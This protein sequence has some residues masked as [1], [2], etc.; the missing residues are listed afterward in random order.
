MNKGVAGFGIFLLLVAFAMLIKA[1]MVEDSEDLV[2][3]NGTLMSSSMMFQ[4]ILGV[5]GF[6]IMIVGLIIINA[7]RKTPKIKA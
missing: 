5:F 4:V 2:L 6:F 1:A 7:S 3:I